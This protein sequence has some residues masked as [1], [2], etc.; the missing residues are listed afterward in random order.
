MTC[1][2][3]VRCLNRWVSDDGQDRALY[4][5]I[6]RIYDPWSRSVV[7]DLEFYVEQAPHRRAARRAGGGTTDRRACS[8]G[9]V[10]V[11]GVDESP[12]CWPVRA[13][14]PRR[15]RGRLIDLRLGDLRD[16]PVTGVPRDRPVCRCSMPDES[17]SPR[18]LRRGVAA[19]AGW[20]ARLRR[21]RPERRG[22]PETD[23]ICSTRTRHLRARGLERRSRTLVLSVR[24]GS[25]AT[26]E[27]TGSAP[28]GT[29]DRMPDSW[30]ELYGWF[31]RH[32]PRDGGDQIWVCTRPR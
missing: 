5:R 31:D 24:G 27:P 16:P 10:R 26:F 6:A 30:P 14:T 23:G 17:R 8:E 9:G 1:A 32:R 19:R 12:E 20:A 21:L 25:G 22:H 4:D 29:P 15:G 28:G 11:I 3:H 2:R 13:P 18:A 7:E